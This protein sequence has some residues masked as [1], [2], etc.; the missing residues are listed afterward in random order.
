MG[1]KL[2][3]LALGYDQPNYHLSTPVTSIWRRRK[4]LKSGVV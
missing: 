2:A 3:L 1:V 4:M